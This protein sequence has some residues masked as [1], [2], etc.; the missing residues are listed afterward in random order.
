MVGKGFNTDDMPS[1]PDFLGL[2]GWVSV[3]LGQWEASVLLCIMLSQLKTLRSW[4][5]S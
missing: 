4:L 2:H 3:V 5:P 1:L